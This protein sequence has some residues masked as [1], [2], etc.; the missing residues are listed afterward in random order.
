MLADPGYVPKLAGLAQQKAAIEDLI[1]LWQF[2]DEH[3]CILCMIPF[4]ITCGETLTFADFDILPAA[5]LADCNLVSSSICAVISKD[6]YTLLLS[7]WTALQLTWVTMLMLVQLLQVSR[8]QTTFE[9]MRSTRHMDDPMHRIPQAVTAAVVSGA[10][11]MEG[12]QLTPGG[13]GPNPV[14]AHGSGPGH[15]H[16]P[17]SGH[18]HHPHGGG[19]L[20]QW[21][22]LFGIDA[23]M[24]TARGG[25]DGAAHGPSSRNPFSRGIM[26]NC[27]DFWC[28]GA[29]VFGSRELGAAMLGGQAVN[30]LRMY[31]T[32]PRLRPAMSASFDGAGR[33]A[34]V[35]AEESV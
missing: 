21:K 33:H 28:D 32:P 25:L 13:M 7:I 29:P 27:K 2:D 12:A 20:G 34:S 5:T 35:A 14:L 30:Y 31:E 15:G 26:G 8:A 4:K 19:V 24:A 9:N 10:T 6:S 11:S 22:A 17:R 3:Y 16:T 18:H 1:A 23:F